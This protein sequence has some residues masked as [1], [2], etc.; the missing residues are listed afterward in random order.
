MTQPSPPPPPDPAPTL[1]IHPT[2]DAIHDCAQDLSRLL[3]DPDELLRL[4]E[5]SE[6]LPLPRRG[7]RLVELF[8]DA[9]LGRAVS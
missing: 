8:V 3:S 2:D 6:R 5:R 1:T 9:A 4:A 7:A